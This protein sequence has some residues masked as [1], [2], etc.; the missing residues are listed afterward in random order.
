MSESLVIRLSKIFGLDTE[1]HDLLAYQSES[2]KAWN[3]ICLS[4]TLQ[5]YWR[6]AYFGFKVLSNAAEMQ[7]ST[8]EWHDITLQLL[9][10][11][12]PPR[13]QEPDEPGLST[14]DLDQQ[15]RG[16]GIQTYVDSLNSFD[17]TS[18]KTDTFYCKEKWPIFSGS[19]FTVRLSRDDAIKFIRMME[20]QWALVKLISMS[21]AANADPIDLNY[22]LYH[23]PEPEREAR[24]MDTSERVS[25]WLEDAR[26]REAR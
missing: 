22:D 12:Q 23:A 6:R 19:V 20:L 17:H 14:I 11:P 16:P 9:W 15:T 10:L 8:E 4:S 26:T 3:M 24:N 25:R 2:D 21:G 13:D 1:T 18:R 7:A 5:N